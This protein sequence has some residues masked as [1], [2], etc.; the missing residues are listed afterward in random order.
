MR[1]TSL[2]GVLGGFLSNLHHC[3]GFAGLIQLHD[4]GLTAGVR[5]VLGLFQCPV[6]LSGVS[7]DA[8]VPYIS[9]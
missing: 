4:E 6:F 2:N 5:F 9:V 8:S 1:L 3:M 7:K